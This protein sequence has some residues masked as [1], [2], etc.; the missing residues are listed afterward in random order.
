[1]LAPTSQHRELHITHQ[2]WT[3]TGRGP[4]RVPWP[5]GMLQPIAPRCSRAVPSNCNSIIRVTSATASARATKWCACIVARVGHERAA[6]SRQPAPARLHRSEPCTQRANRPQLLPILPP[7][8]S[9]VADR[10]PSPTQHLTGTAP[11]HSHC[12]DLW[13]AT[14]NCPQSQQADRVPHAVKLTPPTS[15]S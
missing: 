4:W 5:E 13:T 10:V 1:M 2:S 11:R 8:R 14:A 7:Q 6:E 9:H 12:Q 15:S 3:A